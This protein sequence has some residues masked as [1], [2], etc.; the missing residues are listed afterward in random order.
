MTDDQCR[1]QCSVGDLVISREEEKSRETQ[2]GEERVAATPWV[3]DQG[4]Q[5]GMEVGGWR[6][7]DQRQ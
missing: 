1:G 4:E 3:C 2:K 7:M 6:D 5:R